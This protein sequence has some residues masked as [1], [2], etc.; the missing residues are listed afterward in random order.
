M[1]ISKKGPL[2]IPLSEV[3]PGCFR[4]GPGP[5]NDVYSVGRQLYRALE[6]HFSDSFRHISMC[7]F[8]SGSNIHVQ[9]SCKRWDITYIYI[10]Y[11]NIYVIYSLNIKCFF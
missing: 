8:Q 9:W 10:A 11:V 4:A 6:V 1:S 5:L 7:R 2:S 3:S